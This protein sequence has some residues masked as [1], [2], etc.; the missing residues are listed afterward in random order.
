[1]QQNTCKDSLQGS[2]T[3]LKTGPMLFVFSALM[4]VMALA[5]A[6]PAQAQP[7]TLSYVID[8]DLPDCAL[9]DC[10]FDDPSGNNQELGPLNGSDTKLSVI[11]D[12]PLPMLGFTSVPG[13][14]DL[15]VVY[16]EA[17]D[18]AAGDTWLYFAWERDAPTGSTVIGIEIG[19]NA[20]PEACNFEGLDQTSPA[21]PAEQN[22][23]DNCNPWA[24]RPHSG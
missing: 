4:F 14:S 6:A 2:L 24:N 7:N 21:S 1:M 3:V 16:F 18:D 11:D 9:P 10:Q 23:I 17:Q 13:K 20:P 5:L 8:G 15:N 22:L 19:Q 12:A